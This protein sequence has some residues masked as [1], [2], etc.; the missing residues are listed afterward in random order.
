ME[1]FLKAMVDNKMETA[2]V[3]Q[4]VVLKFVWY[5]GAHVIAGRHTSDF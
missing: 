5:I 2:A 4:G 1:N 3:G